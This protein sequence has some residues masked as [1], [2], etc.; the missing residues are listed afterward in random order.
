MPATYVSA[1]ST[2]GNLKVSGTN[3]SVSGVTWQASDVLVVAWGCDNLTASTPTGTISDSN[4]NTWTQLLQQVNQTSTGAAVGVVAGLAVCRV[5]IPGAFSVTLTLSG[6]VTAKALA[7]GC[8]SSMTTTVL[9]SGITTVTGGTI[10]V[11]VDP[12]VGNLLIGFGIHED[13]SVPATDTDTFNGSWATSASTNTTGGAANTNIGVTLQH[14]IITT[15]R[16]V[17]AQQLDLTMAGD[18]LLGYASLREAP[19]PPHIW[20]PPTTVH[21]ASRW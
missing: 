8:F 1:R 19:E 12:S 21:R 3:L 13:S 6:A 20:T 14:K 2:A 16:P 10:A 18:S 5:T 17:S 7:V 9:D 15:P 11:A 4:A